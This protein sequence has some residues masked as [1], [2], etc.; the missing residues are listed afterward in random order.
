MN[1]I[2]SPDD[3]GIQRP[4]SK[5]FQVTEKHS[6]PSYSALFPW[7]I[8]PRDQHP[9]PERQHY[10]EH[11][12]SRPCHHEGHLG[13]RPHFHEER[14]GSRSHHRDKYPCS[15]PHYHEEHLDS[16]SHHHNEHPGPGPCHRNEQSRP[17]YRYVHSR[18]SLY[19]ADANSEKSRYFKFLMRNDK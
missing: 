4:G 7:L 3:N 6:H 9:R 13:P 15:S 5:S 12:G 2:K 8:R 10:E 17:R 19:I 11:P 14:L 16:R 18:I 1:K